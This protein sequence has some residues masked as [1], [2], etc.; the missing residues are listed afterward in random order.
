MSASTVE[1]ASG[2]HTGVELPGPATRFIEEKQEQILSTDVEELASLRFSIVITARWEASRDEDPSHKKELRTEL[3]DLRARY[4][5]KI[6]RI[7]M[8]FGVAIAIQIKEEVERRVTLPLNM[9]LAEAVVQRDP[10][11]DPQFHI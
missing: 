1:K 3:E 7:A 8:A 10:D 11:D 6:D 2:S 4:F 5:D 9:N